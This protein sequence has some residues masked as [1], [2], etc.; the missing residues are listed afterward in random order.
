MKSSR[1]LKVAALLLFLPRLLTVNMKFVSNPFFD[2][3]PSSEDVQ[4]SV[5]VKYDGLFARDPDG[6]LRPGFVTR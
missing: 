6:T 3:L 1:M 4:E 5:N 2:K